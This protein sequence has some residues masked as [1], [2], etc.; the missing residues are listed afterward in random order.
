MVILA[1]LCTSFELAKNF[2]ITGPC[3]SAA[4]CL[5]TILLCRF[6]AAAQLAAVAAVDPMPPQVSVALLY[7]PSPL[8]QDGSTHLVYEMRV[9]NYAPKSYAVDTLDVAAG[10][11]TFTFAGDELKNMISVL[12]VK[13]PANAT[14]PLEG[15]RTAIIYFTLDL[16]H[17]GKPPDVL[18]HTVHLIAPDGARHAISAPALTVSQQGPISVAPPL[19]GPNWIAGDSSHNSPDAA[20]RRTIAVVDGKAWLAQRYAIDWVQ[21]RM[22]DGVAGTSSGPEDH[23]SSYYCYDAPVLSSTAGKVV[24]LL[25]GIPE[26]VPHSE[27]K[28]VDINLINVGGNHLVVDIG[29]GRYAFYAHMRPGSL[30]V[31]LGDQV[32]VGQLLGNVGNSG[33]SSEPHL[34]M[35][36]V[37]HFSTTSV[38]AANGVPYTFTH[39]RASGSTEL[40]E[41]P[42]QVI[43][44]RNIGRLTERKNDYPA[45][46]AAVEFP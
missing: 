15:G 41:K 44:I 32:T 21:Y 3:R 14:Q 9:T 30:R 29:G 16:G 26:N 27:K 39:C 28:A 38:L 40:I 8:V 2:K 35:H 17:N 22:S 11:R 24:G 12:G 4:V 25:D 1:A 37:D 19:R 43:E 18:Q 6:T 20:H 36:V 31:K 10:A 23:N 46:N 42:H 7:P 5:L 33:N 45:N 13:A 34:H